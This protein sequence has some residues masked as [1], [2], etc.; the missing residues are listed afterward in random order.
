MEHE[1]QPMNVLRP[2]G[3]AQVH[4][5]IRFDPTCVWL[6]WN[7]DHLELRR[8]A[9]DAWQLKRSDAGDHVAEA[10]RDEPYLS[11]LAGLALSDESD[12]HALRLEDFRPLLACD[13]DD[14]VGA[15]VARPD[16][17]G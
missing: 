17:G 14:S 12:E 7:V 11:L 1:S 13:L 16:L 8:P 3:T 10:G 2:F 6:H 9:C 15:V 4:H 5:D